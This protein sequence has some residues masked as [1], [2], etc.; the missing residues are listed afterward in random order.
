MSSSES[1]SSTDDSC[2]ATGTVTPSAPLS[3]QPDHR[4][5]RPFGLLA[6]LVRLDAAQ[7]MVDDHHGQIGHAHG[8]GLQRREA[9][10][11]RRWRP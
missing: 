11:R 9:G 5:H 10:E 4:G 7:G 8:L 2:S 3:Q 1:S 6:H